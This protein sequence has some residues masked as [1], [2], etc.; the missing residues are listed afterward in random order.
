M[1][2]GDVVGHRWNARGREPSSRCHRARYP[3]CLGPGD[4]MPLLNVA[5]RLFC[6]KPPSVTAQGNVEFG[7]G[8]TPYAEIQHPTEARVYV[9]I[10]SGITVLN[11]STRTAP[12]VVGTVTAAAGLIG[13]QAIG[14][15]AFDSTGRYL[16]ATSGATSLYTFDL[17][18]ALVN[19]DDPTLASTVTISA[20]GNL[21]VLN[22]IG[23]NLYI[24]SDSANNFQALSISTPSTPS[25]SSTTSATTI[26]LACQ[27]GVA[28][29]SQLYIY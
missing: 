22:R 11:I 27:V 13:N 23:S 25:V 20:G 4:L 3:R 15:F 21:H 24:L 18:A 7:S 9:V 12:T 14:G 10:N 2:Q 6:R 29:P 1:V 17:G 28:P 8:G 26:A 16:Y 19:K 5:P